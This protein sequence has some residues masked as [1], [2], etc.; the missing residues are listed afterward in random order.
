[1]DEMDNG[2][3]TYKRESMEADLLYACDYIDWQ[4]KE[5]DNLRANIEELIRS[6][7]K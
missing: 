4:A 5:I 7:K 2:G 1:M 3:T 6:Y